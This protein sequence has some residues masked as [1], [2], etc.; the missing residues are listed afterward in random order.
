MA[1][2]RPDA[3]QDGEDVS[4]S[5]ACPPPASLP[6]RSPAHPPAR[7]P[8]PQFDFNSIFSL[9]KP[10]DAA[11]GF[12]SGAKSVAKGILA[13]AVGLVAAPAI[14]A[15]QDGFRGF[16]KGAAAGVAG[17]VLLP[18]T[19]VAVGTTQVVRGED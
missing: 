16:A 4:W 19:G 7:P 11:A 13:G 17:A 6:A 8:P 5:P 2:Q 3:P 14:G 18:V 9:R 1:Q 12:S 15:S 10:K